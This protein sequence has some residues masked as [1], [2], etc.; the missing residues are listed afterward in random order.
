MDTG[1]DSTPLGII[2]EVEEQL[3]DF[4]ADNANPNAQVATE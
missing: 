3:G 2:S 4:P 1:S